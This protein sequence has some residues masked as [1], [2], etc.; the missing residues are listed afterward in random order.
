M[1]Y[2]VIKRY[3]DLSLALVGG[4]LFFPL[5]FIIAILLV[6]EKGKPVFYLKKSLGKDGRVFNAIK[7]CSMAKGSSEATKLGKILRQ[8]AMDELPQ[9]INI[10]KGEMS[11][12]GPRNYSVDKYKSAKPDFLKRLEITPGLTGLAQI[13]VPKGTNNNDVLWHDLQYMKKGNFIMDLQIIVL[14]IWIALNRNCENT[15]RKI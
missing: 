4:V 8:T 1:E 9:L 6:F 10:V 5:F 15:I 14:S 13:Y 2:P 3:F 11:F 12:V 7:F